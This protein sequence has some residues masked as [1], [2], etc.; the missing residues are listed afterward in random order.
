MP[1]QLEKYLAEMTSA[2]F[3][4]FWLD[5]AAKATVLLLVAIAATA[6]FR[7]SSAA[8]RHRIWCMTFAALVLLPGLSAALPEWRLAILPNRSPLAGREESGPLAPQ[9]ERSGAPT[10]QEWAGPPELQTAP[11]LAEHAGYE[12]PLQGE[13]TAAETAA[14]H[15][16]LNLAAFWL[17]GALL[18]LSPLVAGLAR[19]LLLRRQARP[20]DSDVWTS[21]LD[22]LRQRLALARRVGLYEID[23]ALMP[24]TWGVLRPVVL[25]PRHAR[26]WSDRLR[27]FVLLHELA[28]VKRCDV[29]FQILGRFA[30][31]VYW[32][33]PLTWYALRRLRIERELACDD[34]VVL[35]GERATDYAAE[36]LQIARSYRPVPFAAA[37]AMA[38]RGNLEH[39]LCALFDRACSHLPVS[40]RAARLLLAGVLVLVTAVAVVRLAPRAAAD[41]DKNANTSDRVPSESDVDATVTEQVHDQQGKQE[42]A[43]QSS[44]AGQLVETTRQLRVRVFDT[45]EKPVVGARVRVIRYDAHPALVETVQVVGEGR[46]DHAGAA[47]VAFTD[48]S[49]FATGDVLI[50]PNF[51]VFADARGYAIDWDNAPA[52]GDVTLRL[53]PDDVAIEGRVLDL[54]GRPRS[55]VRVNV[56]RVEGGAENIGAWIEAAKHNPAVVDSMDDTAVER[57]SRYPGE[58]FL[59]L[60]SPPVVLPTEVTDEQGRFRL[61]GL[62]RDRLIELELTASGMAK[63]WVNVL[64]RDMSPLPYPGW[65]DPRYRVQSCFGARFDL[66]AEPEQPI[67][68]VVRDADSGQPLAGVEVRLNEYADARFFVE[69]FL[70]AMTDM[71]GRYSLHGVPKPR[72]PKRNHVLRLIPAADQP[73]FRT[74]FDVPKRDGQEPVA[75]DATLKRAIWVRGRVTDAVSGKP[76]R[77]MVI[78]RPLLSNE[79]AAGYPRFGNV[80]LDRW[81]TRDDGSYAVPALPGSGLVAFVAERSDR[82]PEAGADAIAELRQKGTDKLNVDFAWEL[83]LSNALRAI[84][85]P[86]EATEA[87]CDIGLRPLDVARVELVDVAGASLPGALTRHITPVR[88]AV[89]YYSHWS[90]DPLPAATAEIVDP[91]DPSRTAMFLHRERKLAGA[92][93]LSADTDPP[94]QVVLRPCA[95]ISGRIVD[96][97]GKPVPDYSVEVEAVSPSSVRGFEGLGHLLEWLKTGKDGRFRIELVPPGVPYALSAPL[98]RDKLEKTTAVIQPGEAVDL[99]DLRL[100]PVGAPAPAP[101]SEKAAAGNAHASPT[102]AEKDQQSIEFCGRVV[103][104][105]GD[106][107]AGAR[108]GLTYFAYGGRRDDRRFRFQTTTADDGTFKLQVPHDQR[109][110]VSRCFV[111]AAK[112]GYGP[113]WVEASPQDLPSDLT[114]KLARGGA[115]IEGRIID[116][117]GRP[118]AGMEVR[119]ASLQSFPDDNPQ[120]YLESLRQGKPSSPFASWALPLGA[121][122]VAYLS[123]TLARTIEGIFGSPGWGRTAWPRWISWGKASNTL[124]SWSSRI[125]L[126][127]RC[128]RQISHL[129]QSACMGL[130][131]RTSC[132]RR[133]RSPAR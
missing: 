34:C 3:A 62:G 57:V 67:T 8:L 11:P 45:N 97:D 48:V 124:G 106:A 82:Y 95:S 116:L 88:M 115:A 73:Y 76:I 69:G 114:L 112:K 71:K 81:P 23:S 1:T 65:G 36:L 108:V 2:P 72:D 109:F 120:P 16:P 103:G 105:E 9:V 104:P 75:C 77:G 84:N 54:E 93:R 35:A 79:A 121:P 50:A 58:R 41:D 113:G 33:H 90:R 49:P 55:G 38:Q 86:A 125:P 7:R 117:E 102:A 96:R 127:M 74:E 66:A 39:R 15:P 123:E 63:A 43:A 27:R 126:T 31:A 14:T 4:L 47:N 68:G 110:G 94:K 130:A 37:V 25:L 111:V 10:A 70:S 46:T 20:I 6:L 40:A 133:V 42:P 56:Y 59:P 85:P 19:T 51:L 60:G 129:S 30:C 83:E 132:A 87:V 128:K 119:V 52:A 99:G 5:A 100:Q 131:L 22:E 44:A 26:A 18:A 12:A 17:V 107:V 98:R 53:P 29:G 101:D 32:F 122:G 91:R 13:P 80:E 64:T 78:Y 24:M 61:A 21:L 28:H 118:V 89:G 92:V